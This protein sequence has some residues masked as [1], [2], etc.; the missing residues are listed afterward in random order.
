MSVF[1][2]KIHARIFF[3]SNF[4][5]LGKN[6]CI[7]EKHVYNIGP[8][9]GYFYIPRKSLKVTTIF[10]K[11]CAIVC[12]FGPQNTKRIGYCRHTLGPYLQNLMTKNV[13]FVFIYLIDS[14]NN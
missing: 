13:L 10:E 14:I 2:E 4:L 1:T 9:R 8:I 12:E 11:I 6:I 7:M 3:N 5:Y